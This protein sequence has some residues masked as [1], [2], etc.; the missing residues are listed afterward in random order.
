MSNTHQPDAFLILPSTLYEGFAIQRNTSK[1][2]TKPFPTSKIFS[3][4]LRGSSLLT[5]WRLCWSLHL[6]CTTSMTDLCEYSDT[7]FDASLSPEKIWNVK[8]RHLLD[9]FLFLTTSC[10]CTKSDLNP[11]VGYLD[12]S[13]P[14]CLGYAALSETHSHGMSLFGEMEHPFV[15]LTDSIQL[16][17]IRMR[18][19]DTNG[20]RKN[21]K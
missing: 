4:V 1:R 15:V 16:Q 10:H 2:D 11:A 14:C 17:S 21:S 12:R 3:T 7:E 19:N 6:S 20:N 5:G 13:F 8:Q 18:G 9:G